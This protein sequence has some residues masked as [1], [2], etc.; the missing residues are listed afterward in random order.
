MLNRYFSTRAMK[1]VWPYRSSKFIR[2]V[3]FDDVTDKIFTSCCRINKTRINT[4]NYMVPDETESKL[5]SYYIFCVCRS[6]YTVICFRLVIA[7]IIYSGAETGR[8][9]LEA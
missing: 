2:V 1:G 5:I 6:I 7:M 4:L 3:L 8:R 9:V